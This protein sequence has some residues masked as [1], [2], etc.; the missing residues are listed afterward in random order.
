[1]IEA[2]N[3]AWCLWILVK[4][5]VAPG[6]I[7]GVLLAG[8]NGALS[9]YGGGRRGLGIGRLNRRSHRHHQGPGQKYSKDQRGRDPAPADLFLSELGGLH[10]SSQSAAVRSADGS[11]LIRGGADSA[12]AGGCGKS[13]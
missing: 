13:A 9:R 7:A 12:R 6:K 11:L 3:A 1:M 4:L 8:R 10:D 2:W 5:D